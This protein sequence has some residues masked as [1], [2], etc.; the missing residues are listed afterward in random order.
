MARRRKNHLVTLEGAEDLDRALRQVSG[1]ATGL[2]LARAAD[3]GAQVIAEEAKRLAPRDTGALA[4]GITVQPGKLQQG[5]AQINVGPGKD[6]WYGALQELGT[7]HMPAHPFLRPALEGKKDE[8]AEAVRDVLR[9][10]LKGF[11]S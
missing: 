10:A 9:E 11:L 8:A 1:R 6:E 4:D 5:R 7:E 3:A 2:T